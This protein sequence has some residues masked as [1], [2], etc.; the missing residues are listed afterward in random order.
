M[1]NIDDGEEATNPGIKVLVRSTFLKILIR[2]LM[3]MLK[4]YLQAEYFLNSVT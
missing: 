3:R 1:P 4:V 2:L